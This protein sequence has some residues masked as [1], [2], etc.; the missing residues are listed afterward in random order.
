MIKK[1]IPE[2]RKVL[3][4]IEFKNGHLMLIYSE[5]EK[6]PI[7]IKNIET[8]KIH[9]TKEII[10]PRHHGLYKKG[11]NS[12][13]EYYARPFYAETKTDG[14]G[15]I[16]TTKTTA[17]SGDLVEFTI[18]PKEG[19]KLENV[20]VTDSNGNVVVFKE[21]KFTMPSADVLIEV[22]FAVDN[23]ITADIAIYIAISLA[24]A[25]IFIGKINNKKINWI[26][27]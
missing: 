27:K 23:P 14:N 2:D 18:T 6:A 22:T 20:K 11:I 15:T 21:Y 10:L 5:E 17:D 12:I 4:N 25:G 16:T 3:E 7:G 24:I 1:Q 19:Y 13:I 8:D 9:N 26:N